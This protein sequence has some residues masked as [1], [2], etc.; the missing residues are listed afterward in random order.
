MN[1]FQLFKDILIKYSQK[2]NFNFKV[3]EIFE[4]KCNAPND[5]GGVYLIYKLE[6]TI[7]TLLY[8]GSS[9]QNNN[10]VLKVRKGGMKI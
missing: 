9:G 3:N 1:S 4:E 7:E 8:I 10:G 2:D 6:K 5:N